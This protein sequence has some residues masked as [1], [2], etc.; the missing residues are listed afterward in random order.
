MF[1]SLDRY[2]G[3]ARRA[4]EKARD[5]SER[6]ME[7]AE[8]SALRIRGKAMGLFE[9]PKTRT[10]ETRFKLLTYFTCSTCG[11]EI[12]PAEESKVKHTLDRLT[13]ETKAMFN[14]ISV[15][16][17]KQAMGGAQIAGIAL[18]S[19]ADPSFKSL[20]ERDVIR[21][22]RSKTLLIQCEYCGKYHCSSCWNVDR[23]RCV[24]CQ[25]LEFRDILL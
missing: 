7:V 4:A 23:D 20:L 21:D 12:G 8:D 17:V 5:A 19:R 10:V 13:A 1:D 24:N 11:A 15:N 14:V 9:R 16:P 6:A 22:H 18:G 2:M 25:D 3:K